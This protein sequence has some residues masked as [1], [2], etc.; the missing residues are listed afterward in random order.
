[1]DTEGTLRMTREEARRLSI[2]QQVLDRGIQQRHAAE[3]VG[4]SVRQ[5]RRWIQRVRTAGPGGIVH[6][7]RGRPSNRQASA[8]LKQRVLAR[9]RERYLGFGPTL[10]QE[11]LVERDRLRVSRET[12]RQWLREAGL[13]QRQ[14]RAGPQ[15]VWRERKAARG[16][17][18]QLD[19]SH[20]DW[21]EGRGPR[22]VLM[23]YIDDA[24]S[25]V[26]AR[27]YDYEGTM[28]AFESCYGY[29][30]RYG[31]P[32]RLYCDRHGAYWSRAKLRLEDALAGREAPQT[33]FE[34]ALSQLGV[35]VI[36]A[37]SPQAKGRV[38]RLFR[39][40]QDRLIKELRLAG[41]KSRAAANRFLQRY[42]PGYNR[43][44]SCAPRVSADL[45]R[46]APA[47]GRLRRIL[48]RHTRRT[49][50]Q[51]NTL[52]HG[53]QWYV[54]TEP[55]R[56]RRPKQVTVVEQFDGTRL[57]CHGEQ[58]LAHREI[59][60]RPPAAAPR[61]PWPSR[62]RAVVIPKAT[63]P[64]RSDSFLRSRR[65]RELVQA[66]DNEHALNHNHRKEDISTLQERGHF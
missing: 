13:W 49:L 33:Q 10:A 61:F 19:G 55:W 63:H 39:T 59:A 26:F 6:R 45:H 52:Q 16:E 29:V 62:H 32:Q 18:V 41:I 14:R 54:L 53:G 4:R 8:R 58:V 15:H 48:A 22:L 12:L 40:F 21:L 30:I 64:W 5:V 57:I 25:T 46:P 43:R 37:G 1:M 7:L 17:M 11:K 50:R 51:D 23:A 44:F 65:A 27:F 31:L 38:E 47:P 60:P 42:L 9:Y 56:T 2:V 34:R 36:W 20:H 35:E 3:V 28:P 66:L 24:T